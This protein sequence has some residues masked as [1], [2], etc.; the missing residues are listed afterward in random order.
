MHHVLTDISLEIQKGEVLG[1]IGRNG[2]GKST[3]LQILS[4]IIPPTSGSIAIDGTICSILGIGAGFHP[5]LT[6]KE[7]VYL[8][9]SLLGMSKQRN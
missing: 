2:S 5:D 1:I 7:N 3:L 9:G 6:G 4:N 8:N